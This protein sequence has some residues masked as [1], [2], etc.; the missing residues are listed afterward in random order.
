LFYLSLREI[1]TGDDE[2][3]K[4]NNEVIGTTLVS[5][6]LSVQKDLL[7]KPL[8]YQLLLLTRHSLPIVRK[9]AIITIGKL[10]HEVGD[11]YLHL[12]PECI[13]FISE[14]L[15]DS[16]SDVT[17]ATRD[18]IAVIEDLSG[19]KLDSYLIH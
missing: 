11:E 18:T 1:F 8:N 10:F 7:W 4:F 13:Q 3:L 5:L 19:E 2:Y 6:C 9:S 14:L 12:L 15:E 16:N 17:R